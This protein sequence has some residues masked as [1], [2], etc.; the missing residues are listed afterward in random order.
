MIAQ[1][2]EPFTDKDSPYTLK[3]IQIR[4]TPDLPD[5]VL[6]AVQWLGFVTHPG[7]YLYTTTTTGATDH[8]PVEFIENNWY[9]ITRSDDRED[10]YISRRDR[11]ELYAQR[12]GY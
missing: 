6:G 3:D 4:E 1:L 7:Y 10:T 9:F 12:T 8:V 2:L 5:H 11:I